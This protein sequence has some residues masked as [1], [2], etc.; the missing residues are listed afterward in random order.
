MINVKKSGKQTYNRW[1]C[2]PAAKGNTS[3][4]V[5]LKPKIHTFLNKYLQAIT[6]VRLEF[7]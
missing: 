5:C 7:T 1:N 4:D 2:I 3:A 6:E